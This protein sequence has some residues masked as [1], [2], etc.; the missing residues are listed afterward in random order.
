MFADEFWKHHAPAETKIRIIAGVIGMYIIA[1]MNLAAAF[2][3]IQGAMIRF[4]VFLA[5]GTIL[6]LFKSRLCMGLMTAWYVPYSLYYTFNYHNPDRINRRDIT[7]PL[8]IIAFGILVLI[9]ATVEAFR[10]HRLKKDYEEHPEPEVNVPTD[11]TVRPMTAEEMRM[12]PPEALSESGKRNVR[13]VRVTGG[14]KY[15]DEEL[16]AIIEEAHRNGK[17]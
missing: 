16:T 6:L 11:C 7:S 14:R 4:F 5:G 9:A 12:L 2:Y 10:Y 17:I 15:S 3:D 8:G 13:F 1:V